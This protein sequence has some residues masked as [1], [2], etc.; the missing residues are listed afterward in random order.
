MTAENPPKS[1]LIQFLISI[2]TRES[3]KSNIGLSRF[4]VPISI[5]HC[6]FIPLQVTAVALRLYARW[7]VVGTWFAVEDGLVFFTLLHQLILSAIGVGK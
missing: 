2:G 4:I 1:R 3:P 5:I 7:L 6:V